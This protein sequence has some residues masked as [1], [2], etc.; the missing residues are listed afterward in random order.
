MAHFY[1]KMRQFVADACR[2]EGPPD[3]E[4]LRATSLEHAERTVYWLKQLKPDAD[5]AML[6]AAIAHDIERAVQEETEYKSSAVKDGGFTNEGFLREHQDRSASIAAEFL[7]RQDAPPKMVE[8]VKALIMRHEEGGDDD[9]NALK[10]AD[11]ISHFEVAVP[12]FLENIVDEVGTERVR[13]K[14]D[15]M[16][17][18]ITSS[19]AK[20]IAKPL[21]EKAISGLK[22]T[23]TKTE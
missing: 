15:W 8:R 17:D 19:Q 3:M 1:E 4:R 6:I 13:E 21:Y 16:Y 9:Q 2:A 23:Q 14:F 22:R 7:K 20:R 10:D 5:E 11:S 18:R 12:F